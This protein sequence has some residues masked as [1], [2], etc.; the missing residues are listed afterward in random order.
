[1]DIIRENE[2]KI[3]KIRIWN[4]REKE[5]GF[6]DIS[7]DLSGDIMGDDWQWVLFMDKDPSVA[8]ILEELKKWEDA[9]PYWNNG[10]TPSGDEFFLNIGGTYC[11]TV[12][13]DEL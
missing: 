10:E 2:D 5:D 6:L 3:I 8:E 9:V 4:E 11:M 12:E 13:V 1:M 7:E